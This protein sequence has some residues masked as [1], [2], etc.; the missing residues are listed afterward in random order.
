MIDATAAYGVNRRLL[1]VVAAIAATSFA[2]GLLGLDRPLAEWIRASGIENATVFADG[3]GALDFVSGMH[4]WFWL[5]GC[6]TL[7][8]GAAGLMLRRGRQWPRA[9]VGAALVQFATLATMIAG[10][11]HFGRLRPHQ[12]LDGGDW[13]HVWFAGG[14]SFPSGHSAFYFGLLLPLAAT[15]RLPWLRAVLLAIPLFVV[16]ARVDLAK[17]FLSDVSASALI[18]AAYSL[19]LAI[20]ARRW[21][22][23]PDLTS[24]RD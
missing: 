16:A 21:L 5:A 15:C 6:V 8:I 12:V 4:V 23:A 24:T 9:L 2:A 17:H 14:G 3:L 20:P 22:A 7:A 18:A 13:S 11:N 1:V 19:L 10:K